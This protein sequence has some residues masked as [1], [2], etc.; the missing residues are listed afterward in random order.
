MDKK[1]DMD[2]SG[3][4]GNN[5]ALKNLALKGLTGAG[6]GAAGM[7]LGSAALNWNDPNR[8]AKIRN[9]LLS[10][11]ALGGLS[12]LGYGALQSM[13]DSTTPPHTFGEDYPVTQEALKLTSNPA[14]AGLTGA[15]GRAALELGKG[16]NLKGEGIEQQMSELSRKKDVLPEEVVRQSVG[17]KFFRPE[18]GVNAAHAAI[19][20]MATRGV[21]NLELDPTSGGVRTV[22]NKEAPADMT[23]AIR[24]RAAQ[25]IDES[26]SNIEKA[27]G[28]A[29]EATN[30]FLRMKAK[31]PLL[32]EP[33]I[34]IPD[35]LSERDAVAQAVR[36]ISAKGSR[37]GNRE[38][39]SKTLGGRADLNPIETLRNKALNGVG[40]NK[41][42]NRLRSN[43]EYSGGKMDK[44][45]SGLYAKS[46]TDKLYSGARVPSS[47]LPGMAKN[48]AITGA[49]TAAA[50]LAAHHG[51]EG[52]INS[53]L[54]D[55]VKQM[56]IDA[57]K[58]Q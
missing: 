9:A 18:R 4:L 49:L 26:R 31:N 25:L 54:P 15:A 42:L 28:S 44:L 43:P 17:S 14:A 36:E 12:G 52:V 22:L 21:G 34:A 16:T 32:S 46:L 53:T 45:L 27:H 50:D 39:L 29:A 1:A 13:K 5:D 47:N 23:K 51:I 41:L 6:I 24:E 38:D 55:E 58:R 3:I 57:A 11:G 7:G 37:F 30:N 8:K 35:A 48:I 40:V 2:L 10:G 20:N 56:Y 19:N 33:R